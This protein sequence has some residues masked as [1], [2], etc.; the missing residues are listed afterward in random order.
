MS[1]ALDPDP[2]NEVTLLAALASRFGV[3]ARYIDGQTEVVLLRLILGAVTELM[4]S[5]NQNGSGG[6]I[7]KSAHYSAV[8]GDMI[9]ADASIGAF[10]I[11]LPAPPA[12]NDFIWLDIRG[13]AGSG[14]PT[15]DG[16]GKNIIQGSNPAA[17]AV[18]MSQG[19]DGILNLII[20]DGTNWRLYNMVEWIAANPISLSAGS[21]AFTQAPADN[22][23]NVATTAYVDAAVAAGIAALL[24]DITTFST[25]MTVA[26]ITPAPDGVVTPVGAIDTKQGVVVSVS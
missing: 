12:E 4:L 24:A 10:T 14:G 26:G 23:T 20:Y 7:V 17:P 6:W 11:T 21:T 8:S 2:Q 9:I 22:S 13:Q 16:N 5:I 19:Y 1:S 15:V 3:Q 25:L 18:T